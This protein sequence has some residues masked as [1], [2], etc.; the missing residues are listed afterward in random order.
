MCAFGSP[1]Q[2]LTTVILSPDMTWLAEQLQASTCTH[3]PGGHSEIA[4][5]FDGNGIAVSAAAAAYP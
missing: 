2:K 3:G 1:Y 4:V 5:G